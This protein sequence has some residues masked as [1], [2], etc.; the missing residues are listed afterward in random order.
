MRSTLSSAEV[1]AGERFDWFAEVVASALIPTVLRCSQPGEFLADVSV[2]DLGPVQVSTFDYG[3]V[4]SWRTPATIRRSDP[5]QYQ[6]A[7]VTGRPMWIS[8]QRNDS[9]RFLDD[10][11]L[12]DTSRPFEAGVLDGSGPDSLVRATI[13]QW[14][15]D[16]FPFRPERVDRL[17]ARRIAGNQ[18]MGAILAQYL[19]S[20]GE[21]AG[22]CG[23]AERDRLGRV[24][25]DLATACLAQQLDAYDELPAETRAQVLLERVNAFIEHNLGDPRLTPQAIAARHHISVRSLHL[26]FQGQRESVAASIRS[27]RLGRCHADLSDPALLD[28]P[29]HAIAA[30]WGF[31]SAAVFSRGFREAYGLSPSELRRLTEQSGCLERQRG[32]RLVQSPEPGPVLG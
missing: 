18:G 2:L 29:V 23:P 13:I 12:W 1:P 28:R 24:A 9:G 15:K 16:T 22:D 6:L 10:L 3:A 30:R 17:L 8:Q 4:R 26:L 20:L 5:E 31:T 11:V 14:P 19:T 7:L 27:R 32:V 21:H 25:I